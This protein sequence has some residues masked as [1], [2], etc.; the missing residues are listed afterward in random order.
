[1]FNTD[2]YEGC[3][4]SVHAKKKFPALTYFSEVTYSG[5]NGHNF[6]GAQS[7]LFKLTLAIW[8]KIKIS[9]ISEKC[10]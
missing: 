2:K 5:I 3:G 7:V 6:R 9:L 1:M 10:N 4:K 8:T